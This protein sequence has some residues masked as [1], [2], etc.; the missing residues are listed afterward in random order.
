MTDDEQIK[1]HFSRYFSAFCT[2]NAML[3]DYAKVV[4]KL[5]G[6]TPQQ[7]E[8]RVKKRAKEIGD[9]MNKENQS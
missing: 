6:I 9:K 4:A 1:K 7:V 2:S 5:E 8:D 3:E